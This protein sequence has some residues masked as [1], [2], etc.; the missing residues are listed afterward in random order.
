MLEINHKQLVKRYFEE[1]WNKGNL[2][3][4]DE[5]V[6][7]DYINHN[8]GI[9]NPASGPAGLKPIVAAIRKAFP[10]LNYIIQNMVV[11]DDQVAVHTIMQGTHSGDFF[12]I[13]PTNKKIKVDQMQIER[14]ANNKIVEHWRITDEIT[15][16]KQLGQLG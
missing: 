8:P 6:S 7:Q 16:L 9:A 5:I 4:L 11:S 13:S 3:V 10:D 15:L 1:V 12:G 14:I 2:D